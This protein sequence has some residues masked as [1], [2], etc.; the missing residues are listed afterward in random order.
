MP[1]AASSPG[2]RR[3]WP[4]EVKDEAA[5]QML[6]GRRPRE[7]VPELD[8]SFEL[9]AQWK[10][11]YLARQA[12]TDAHAAAAEQARLDQECRRLTLLILSTRA[13]AGPGAVVGT[14][15]VIDGD[16]LE[17][18]TGERIRLCYRRG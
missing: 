2:A 14:A 17:L 15:E 8:V 6:A 16:T 10:R 13:A 11:E 12:R 9:L 3:R 7:L 5:R 4:H 18:A 1:P